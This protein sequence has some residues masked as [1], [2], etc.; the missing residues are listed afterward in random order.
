MTE[1]GTEAE[2]AGART[3]A[4]LREAARL[5]RAAAVE[6]LMR[7]YRWTAAAAER[8]AGLLGDEAADR[9][10]RAAELRRALRE[11]GHGQGQ[12]YEHGR[13]GDEYGYGYGYGHDDR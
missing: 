13:D 7:E 1:T 9:A 10:R 4:A 11:R 6:V 8:F 3:A 5:Y 12:G 2:A